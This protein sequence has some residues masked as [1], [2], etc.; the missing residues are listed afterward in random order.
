[1]SATVLDFWTGEAL[2]EDQVLYLAADQLERRSRE[3]LRQIDVY[4]EA[5]RFAWDETLETV[6]EEV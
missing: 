2:R 3:L 1:M 5:Y 6:V 4:C